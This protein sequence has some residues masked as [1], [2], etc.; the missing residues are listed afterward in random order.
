[1]HASVCFFF[2]FYSLHTPLNFCFSGDLDM[3]KPVESS[4][5]KQQ[6][7]ETVEES[8]L[9]KY[10]RALEVPFLQGEK[11]F[12]VVYT[13]SKRFLFCFAGCPVTS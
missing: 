10:L 12:F 5:G 3:L 8:A 11:P 2:F 1:M 4:G 13:A 9:K 7:A 6:S